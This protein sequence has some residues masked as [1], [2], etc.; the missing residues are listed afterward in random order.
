MR[1]E[2]RVYVPKFVLQYKICFAVFCLK[3][4]VQS[5]R[6]F[7]GDNRFT[8][9]IGALGKLTEL[10]TLCVGEQ[11]VVD[12]VGMCMCIT[13]LAVSNLCLPDRHVPHLAHTAHSGP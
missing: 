12:I 7:I 2:A 9:T 10:H 13:E 6:R 1:S 4:D 3:G 8:G 5:T 11:G